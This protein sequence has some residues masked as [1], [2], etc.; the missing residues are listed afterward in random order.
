VERRRGDAML[1]A[2]AAA[3]ADDEG[4]TPEDDEAAREALAAY[5]RG[6]A[7]SSDQPRRDLGLT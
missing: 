4:S 6:E 2:L 3:P 5:Q 7:V 1:E